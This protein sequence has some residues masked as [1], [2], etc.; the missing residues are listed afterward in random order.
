MSNAIPRL[1]MMGI[2]AWLAIAHSDVPPEQSAAAP[3]GGGLFS[4]AGVLDATLEAPLGELFAKARRNPATTVQGTLTSGGTSID[5]VDVS[6]RGNTS[7]ASG[8]CSF[9]KLKL[10][11][12]EG[13][14]DASIFEGLRSVKIGTHCGDL[15]DE[16]LTHY[17][18][19][20]ND[21]EP[22]R[23]AFIYRLLEAVQVPTLRARPVRITYVDGGHQSKHNGF[24]VEDDREALVRMG[25]SREIAPAQ[26]RDA[27]RDFAPA[28]TANLAF[29]EALIGNFDWCLK[30]T[31]ND[32]YRCNA[33]HPLWNVRAFAGAD[34]HLTPVM[35]DF[36]IAGMVTGRHPW[37]SNVF[38]AGFAASKS[39]A[40][41]EVTSQVQHT[42]SLFPRALLDATRRRFMGRKSAAYEALAGAELDKGGRDIAEAYLANFYHAIDTDAVFYSPVVIRP[43]TSVYLDP[44]G[45]Q[46]ACGRTSTAPV[47]TPVSLPL[48]REGTMARVALLD[49]FWLWAPP[50]KCD[51]VHAGPVWIDA[52]A[53]GSD[54]PSR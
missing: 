5:G 17:G 54:Y 22:F 20:A 32:A 37:F 51:A 50:N 19:M 49:A 53:I 7:A 44:A 35:S 21:K 4:S 41:I 38:Y 13:P 15:P 3:T 34:G 8:E 6:V 40:E 12:T 33:R 23:E 2:A 52:S 9:P 24:F 27:S 45:T 39:T 11:F 30:F 25:A 10:K 18:R 29:G 47:G 28:D 16:Q 31:P 48:Q 36:D 42:R 1:A 43:G 46:P 14:R 26:F